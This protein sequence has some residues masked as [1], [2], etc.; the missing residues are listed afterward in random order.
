MY[1]PTFAVTAAPPMLKC[2]DYRIRK[3][4][5]NNQSGIPR[6]GGP[7]GCINGG[8]GVKVTLRAFTQ[9][10]FPPLYEVLR[11]SKCGGCGLWGLWAG[12]GG[13]PELPSKSEL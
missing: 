11:S 10:G 7:R 6:R 3:V 13:D 1:S 4:R 12:G 8:G 9:N 2:P 5:V